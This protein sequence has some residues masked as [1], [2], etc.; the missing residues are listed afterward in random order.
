L[1]YEIV[2]EESIYVYGILKLSIQ[3]LVEN[4]V[5]H[6]I[7]RKLKGGMVRIQA[8]EVAGVLRIEVYDTGE[9][10]SEANLVRLRRT[11]EM[12]QQV[13]VKNHNED[14]LHIGLSNIHR[15][16]QLLYGT[17]YGV[18]VNSQKG[19]WTVVALTVPAIKLQEGTEG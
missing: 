19:K 16:I 12:G 3:P 11:M 10:I 13:A 8:V 5:T 14:N 17:D 4:A 7:A 6:G 1:T 9:G 2:A 15:R 18:Q